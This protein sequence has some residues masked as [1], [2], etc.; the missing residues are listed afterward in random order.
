[1]FWKNNSGQKRF[2]LNRFF[3]FLRKTKIPAII[4]N[5]EDFGACGGCTRSG[6]LSRLNKVNL[7]SFPAG[8]PVSANL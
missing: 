5:S 1:M 2:V 3:G 6:R 8:N 7:E 4:A